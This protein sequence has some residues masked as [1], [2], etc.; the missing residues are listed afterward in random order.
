MEWWIALWKGVLV[1]FTIAYY[2]L[3]LFIVPTAFRDVVS[4]ARKLGKNSG[5]ADDIA[6]E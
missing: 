2:L 4:L 6:S 5:E 1:V 3:A